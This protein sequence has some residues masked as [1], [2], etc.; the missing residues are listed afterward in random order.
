MEESLFMRHFS[1]LKDPR[2]DRQKKHLLVDIIAIVICAVISGVTRWTEIEDYAEEKKEWLQTFL[3][4]PNGIP[5]HDTFSRV[6]TLLDPQLFQQSFFSWVKE[7]AQ[8]LEG[9]IVAIDGKTLRRSHGISRGKKA[10]HIVSAW[11]TQQQV[12]LAQQKVD[13]KSNEITAIP[14]L[15][16]ILCLK[17]AIVTIDAMGCQRKIAEKIV[18]KEADYVLA[19]KENQG[20]LYEMME[21]TFAVA[22]ELAF[23]NMVYSS[24]QTVDGDHG[25]IETRH[26]TVLPLMYLYQFKLKWKG[27][28]SLVMVESTREIQGKVAT[29]KRYYISSLVSDAKKIGHV[30]RSH[31][32]I[33]NNLHWS[34]DVTLREDD[35]RIRTG[36]APENLAWLRRLVLSLLKK[37]NTFKGSIRRKQFKALMDNDYLLRILKGI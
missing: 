34:L 13:E 20:K 31:W 11:A 6:F 32:G 25:R 10:L 2:I 36:H 7:L 9:E 33:E 16:E 27:L 21:K 14:I 3:Q 19:V 26:Y 37:D 1:D 4:L 23:N 24:H 5:S 8:Q 22:K 17:G 12:I 28:K 35:C 30:I 15:L 29:E 18:A